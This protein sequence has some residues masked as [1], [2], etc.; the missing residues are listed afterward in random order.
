MGGGGGGGGEV[1]EGREKDGRKEQKM[2]EREREK[3]I[4]IRLFDLENSASL[5]EVYQKEKEGMREKS[6]GY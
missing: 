2:S 5:V 4:T 3:K 6:L 1:K